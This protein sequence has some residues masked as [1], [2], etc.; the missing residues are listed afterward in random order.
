MGFSLT[1]LTFYG[2]LSSVDWDLRVLLSSHAESSSEQ[3]IA[4]FLGEAL[5]KKLKERQLKSID[6]E[7]SNLFDY[8]DIGDSI[9]LIFT[10]KSV[11]RP[12]E[13]SFFDRNKNAFFDA[14]PIRNRVMHARPLEFS[15]GTKIDRLSECVT[16]LKSVFAQT[17]IFIEKVK[18]NPY[19]PF[20]LEAAEI[21]A[22]GPAANHNLP[23]PDFDETGFLGRESETQK[24]IAAC[25][26][27]WPI[28]TVVGE[29]GY[30]KTAL[31][32][33]AAYRLLD[34]PANP[35]DYIVWT[36]S[37]TSRLSLREIESIESAIT[38]SMG[39][40]QDV[41]KTLSG[42]SADP[43]NAMSDVLSYLNEFKILLIL[44]NLE[45]VL[46]TTILHL[47]SQLNGRSKIIATSRLGTGEMNYRFP[48]EPL[49][50]EDSVR[51][52]RSTAKVRGV[53]LL[54]KEKQQNLLTYCRRL[55]GN[56]GFIKWFV[57][58]V[59]C[60]KRPEEV[61]VEPKIFLDFCLSNVYDY[62]SSDAKTVASV[63]LAVPGQHT[64]AV[65]SYISDLSG[66][67]FQ[68]A[69]RQLWSA[70]LV[71]MTS[72]ATSNGQQTVY[73]LGELPRLYI[74]KNHPSSQQTVKAYQARK[75]SIE[76]F[77]RSNF[78][79]P[80]RNEYNFNTIKLRTKDDTV[81]AKYLRDAL[82]LG[83]ADYNV[84]L[85]SLEKA[86]SL[87]PGY[88]EVHRVEAI[89]Q[90]NSGNF[91]AAV[92]AYEMAIGCE[93]N[94]APLRY[95][96]AG[97]LMRDADDI[98]GA[99][100]QFERAQEL[101]PDSA[102][103]TMEHA[104]CLMFDMQYDRA[105]DL[106][107]PLLTKTDLQPLAQRKLVDLN[108]QIALRRADV[109][110]NEALKAEALVEV[111]TRYQNSPKDI[112]DRHCQDTMHKA[113]AMVERL[114][115][116]NEHQIPQDELS[117]LVELA[118]SYT[119]F[120][121]KAIYSSSN[122]QRG[123]TPKPGDVDQQKSGVVKNFNDLKNFGFIIYDD[124]V[125]IFFHRTELTNQSSVITPGD[126]VLF[127]V[128]TDG[129]KYFARN[130]NM[131]HTTPTDNSIK[132]GVVKTALQEKGFGFIFTT[133]GRE[134]FFH[135]TNCASSFEDLKHGDAVFFKESIN[136][137]G[138]CADGVHLK[139]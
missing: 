33:Q 41:Q 122:P 97:F 99:L 48:I 72:I 62:V 10:H 64:Q 54:A 81:I 25:K 63:M 26:G 75:R 17:N 19:F 58:S 106:L 139:V 69:L 84:T 131:V 100:Q 29:G 95:W 130:I 70:N 7:Q 120:E 22:A 38:T 85:E 16:S 137:K 31:T 92:E 121:P 126:S 86:K 45:T 24:L 13:Q 82:A 28:I 59:Q 37:K 23:I 57:S 39:V 111:F 18:E 2:I 93:P 119:S 113:H 101:D 61:L 115:S 8:L 98:D 21:G 73:E 76:Q 1:R 47:F 132:E 67:R 5:Y 55:K 123:K 77:Y 107:Q 89:V 80:Q 136:A 20:S 133:D 105:D 46:D 4:S 9:Q 110:I 65:L 51:L 66:D 88:Y 83:N 114:I 12:K 11:L 90:R 43:N 40:I 124:R 50:D 87:D 128:A 79:G 27:P 3:A 108:L 52:L 30:G 109:A 49:S 118:T 102:A 112:L 68:E 104:R 96:Y 42:A 74:I 78:V 56:P 36:T 6:G 94:S 117:I 60:G 103:V 32:L 134:L 15:D 135:K 53:K 129:T 138:A 116:A 91:P 127:T 71:T 14:I 35:F 125:E 44:D 34:D